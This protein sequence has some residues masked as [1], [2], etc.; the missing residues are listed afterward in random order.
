MKDSNNNGAKQA[1]AAVSSLN[2]FLVK[3]YLPKMTLMRR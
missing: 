1:N 2:Y 3:Y